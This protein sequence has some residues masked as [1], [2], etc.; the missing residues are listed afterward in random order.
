MTLTP[1]PSY[2]SYGELVSDFRK[3]VECTERVKENGVFI[4][5]ATLQKFR[6]S[7]I[8]W[9]IFDGLEWNDWKPNKQ[10]QKKRKN[11]PPLQS[12]KQIKLKRKKK[13][14]QKPKQSA[15]YLQTLVNFYWRDF[16]AN[17]S[18]SITITAL[19]PIIFKR[20]PRSFNY[21]SFNS[22]S[23]ESR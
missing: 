12:K 2:F 13:G 16:R 17:N 21:G 9:A 19:P 6:Q 15:F 7:I 5:K 23:I 8:S 10:R 18:F 14:K 4:L 20:K 11:L 3:V 22:R 1:P